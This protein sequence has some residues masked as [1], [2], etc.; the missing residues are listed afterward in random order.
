MFADR[1]WFAKPPDKPRPDALVSFQAALKEARS[2]VPP[3]NEARERFSS[4][5]AEV[6]SERALV[7]D[8]AMAAWKAAAFTGQVQRLRG[9]SE[10]ALSRLN[11]LRVAEKAASEALASAMHN[12]RVCEASFLAARDHQ[13]AKI[14]AA[15]LTASPPNRQTLADEFDQA[16]RRQ[17]QLQRDFD[18]TKCALDDMPPPS[19]LAKWFRPAATAARKQ[20][21]SRLQAELGR[22]RDELLAVDN[23]LAALTQALRRAAQWQEAVQKAEAAVEATAARCLQ[24]GVALN[25]ADVPDLERAAAD[26]RKVAHAAEIAAGEARIGRE[27]AEREL[28]AIKRKLR[29][30]ETTSN[31]WRDERTRHGLSEEQARA[32]FLW[33]IDDAPRQ[34]RAPWYSEK[35]F[36]LRRRLF[37]AALDLHKAFAVHAGGKLRANLARF[38][39]L[40]SGSIGPSQ[41]ADGGLTL[42][43]T[44]FLVVPV[45]STTFASFGRLFAGL[46]RESLGWLLVDEGGQAQPQ[47][48]VGAI[49]RARRTVVVGDPLQVEPVR[50]LPHEAVH[51]LRLHAGV[52]ARWD[53][54]DLGWLPATGPSPV[55]AGSNVRSRQSHRIQRPND[56]WHQAAKARSGE[57]LAR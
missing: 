55:P 21:R 34:L 35:L 19:W 9:E 48:A 6:E 25:A 41:L 20:E 2:S 16:G 18:V 28:E 42:W 38:A 1:F 5:L 51:A 10:R 24:A 56:L 36:N 4:L 27:T 53:P 57:G 43:E 37:L 45:V 54:R 33:Y 39:N 22:Q 26:A 7:Q 30:V 50:T 12:Q 17:I 29:E 49:W 44:L 8:K 13:A 40:M 23:R 11:T 52:E 3:W 15:E 14:R 32:W 46:D 47:D 31:V